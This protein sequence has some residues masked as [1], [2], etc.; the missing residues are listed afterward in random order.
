MT[1]CRRHFAI[2]G[3]RTI[4]YQLNGTSL[5]KENGLPL[6]GSMLIGGRVAFSD[7]DLRV[8]YQ[9]G[10]NK[11]FAGLWNANLRPSRGT[12]SALRGVQPPRS[13]QRLLPFIHLP[14]V[15]KSR[16]P[17][18]AHMLVPPEMLATGT[19]SANQQYIPFYKGCTQNMRLSLHETGCNLL[20]WAE[21]PGPAEGPSLREARPAEVRPGSRAPRPVYTGV[22]LKKEAVL[23]KK[24][25]RN[26]ATTQAVLPN[27]LRAHSPILKRTKEPERN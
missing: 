24:W 18:P 27:G 4:P 19:K 14:A 22:N 26:T 7:Y 5:S 15:V 13:K 1:V 17:S 11:Y 3:T 8:R 25:P 21:H 16:H 9:W 2:W 10:S 12:L 23:G 6:S 20:T